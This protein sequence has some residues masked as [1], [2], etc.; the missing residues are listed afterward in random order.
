MDPTYDS[1]PELDS[2]PPA[3]TRGRV[4]AQ[5]TVVVAIHLARLLWPAVAYL[6]A[7]FLDLVSAARLSLLW[8]SRRKFPD[9]ARDLDTQI[10][11]LR[12]SQSKRW[13]SWKTLPAGRWMETRCAAA[14]LAAVAILGLRAHLT[15]PGSTAERVAHRPTTAHSPSVQSPRGAASTS[16]T[17]STMSALDQARL[18]AEHFKEYR[19]QAAPG[20]WV[21]YGVEPV[22]RSSARLAAAQAHWWLSRR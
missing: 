22:D 20:Q 10:A 11:S 3:M 19:K 4:F 6:G 5:A 2:H 18:D 9:R 8:R 14:V 12:A 16:S 7:T 21:T 13:S 1:R 17:P 15:G